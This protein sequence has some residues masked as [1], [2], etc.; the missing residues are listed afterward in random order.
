[1]HSASI[2]QQQQVRRQERVHSI[3]PLA[4]KGLSCSFLSVLFFPFFPSHSS[5]YRACLSVSYGS[6][7]GVTSLGLFQIATLIW[8]SNWLIE[9]SRRPPACVALLYVLLYVSLVCTF[10]HSNCPFCWNLC[11]NFRCV[12]GTTVTRAADW[13][14][15]SEQSP[16]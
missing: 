12:R 9:S 14:L 11:F 1:M 3:S 6:V 8:F 4:A 7:D 2:Y 10:S 5:M 16:I 13:A 15:F